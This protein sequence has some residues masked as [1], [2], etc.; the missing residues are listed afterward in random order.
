MKPIIWSALILAGSTL[1]ASAQN[2]QNKTTTDAPKTPNIND[3]ST[4]ESLENTEFFGN[5]TGGLQAFNPAISAIIDMLYYHEDSDESLSHMKEEMPGFASHA[6]GEDEHD[7]DHGYENG[8][9]LGELELAF[10]AEV[11]NYFR[12]QA[13]IA[14]FEDGAEIEEAWAETTGLPWGLQAKAGK[15]KSNFGYINAKHKHEWEFADQPLIY[16]LAFGDH[17]L[18]DVGAQISWLAPTSKYFLLF[19]AEVFQGDDENLFA[20]ADDDTGTLPEDDGPHLGVGWVKFAPLQADQHEFQL[21][22]FGAIGR[23]QE[24]HEEGISTN[25]YDGLSSFVGGDAVYMFDSLKAYGQGDVKLQAEYYLGSK[26]LDQQTAPGTLTSAQDGYY[27]Q[28][29]YGFLPR[30]NLGLRWDQVGLTNEFQEPGEDKEK[31]GDS[32]RATAM[33]DFRPSEF[34]LIRFQ[35]DNGD[36]DLGDE[37]VQNVWQAFVQLTFSIGAHGA[38]QF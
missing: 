16:E 20:R 8:F 38:H 24:I 7:H 37:G 29:T 15:F 25:Y 2:E 17:G 33:V 34:S 4:M 18:D 27:I 30:W 13:I 19:G 28:G 1:L 35:L 12:A 32:W 14:L 31:Y 5:T 9:N 22:L 3:P 23:H 6:H 10:A 36:Y 26:D 11:D 21:G